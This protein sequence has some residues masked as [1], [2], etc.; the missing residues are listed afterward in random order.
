MEGYRGDRYASAPSKVMLQ[1]D[2]VTIVEIV[3]ESEDED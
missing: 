2:A 1:G 3:L